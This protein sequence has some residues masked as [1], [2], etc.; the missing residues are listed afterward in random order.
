MKGTKKNQERKSDKKTKELSYMQEYKAQTDEA[1]T[2]LEIARRRTL[3]KLE[4]KW[5][6]E[7]EVK[8]DIARRRAKVLLG[9]KLA[10]MD[11]SALPPRKGDNTFWVTRVGEKHKI[12]TPEE[13]K[14]SRKVSLTQFTYELNSYRA[15]AKKPFV[16]WPK[17]DDLD[18]LS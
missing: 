8:A 2:L 18:R 1:E 11:L 17:S 6:K 13:E 10:F 12:H 14:G 7:K 5:K 16:Y 3:V 15:H 4:E 9:E